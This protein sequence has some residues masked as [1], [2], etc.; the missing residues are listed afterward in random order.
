MS[1]RLP[2]LLTVGRLVLSIIFFVVLADVRAEGYD[3]KTTGLLA[4]GLVIYL[5]A[6]VTDVLDGYLA[7]RWKVTSTFGR[8]A[9]PIVDKVIVCGAFAMFAGRNFAA[10]SPEVLC[11]F[12]RHLPEW[13]HGQMVSGVQA[14]MAVVLIARE[15]IISGIRGYSESQG[16]NFPAT[17]AGKAKM[18][19]QSAAVCMILV[20]MAWLSQ[21]AWAVAV[22]LVLVWLTVITTV[23]SGLVYVR[24][25]GKLLRESTY[26]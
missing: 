3:A 10:V 22:K 16:I 24:R 12:Q 6:G 4:A 15:F 26:G 20:Q 8:L 1:K 17:Q 23:A 2:N 19:V 7:R 9:D 25:A 14:W 5:I 13:V 21:S 18:F 11:P